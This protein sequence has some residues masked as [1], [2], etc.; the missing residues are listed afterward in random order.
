[1]GQNRRQRLGR[2]VHGREHCQRVDELALELLFQLALGRIHDA[3]A[4]RMPA[5]VPSNTEMSGEY[6]PVTSLRSNQ[7]PV[8]SCR[9]HVLPGQA[10]LLIARQRRL[11]P[12]ERYLNG[13]LPA[14]HLLAVVD[15]PVEDR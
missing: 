11:P 13:R 14:I 4:D 10:A 1:M 6:L 8:D 9:E 5:K 2:L 15:S 12:R 3:H 7:P